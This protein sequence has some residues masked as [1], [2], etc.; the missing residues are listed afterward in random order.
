M[1][2]TKLTI[3]V[4]FDPSKTDGEGLATA[5][6][7][8]LKTAMSTPSILDEYGEVKPSKDG[9]LCSEEEDGSTVVTV[10]VI[11]FFDDMP[12][13]LA[14]Y[15]DNKKGN[16]E[17]EKRFKAIAK[18]NGTFSDEDLEAYVEDGI[19]EEGTWKAVLF[20]STNEQQPD[21][22]DLEAEDERD[23]RRGLYGPEYPNEKF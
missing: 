8:L 1:A 13:G 9:F 2:K 12:I 15:L 14:S 3:E 10:N 18:E 20:H 5:F 22:D 21:Q 19:V 23:S 4:E 17:A 7:N 16:E 6:D 11:E